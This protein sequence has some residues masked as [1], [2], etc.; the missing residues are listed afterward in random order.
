MHSSNWLAYISL[1]LLSTLSPGPAVLLAMSNAS[2]QGLSAAGLSSLGNLAGLLC[3]S[4]AALLG[5]GTVLPTSSTLFVGLKVIG[6]GYLVY[7]VYLGIR[8]FRASVNVFESI[9][10]AATAHSP[11]RLFVEGATLALTNPKAIFSSQPSF[12]T[13]STEGVQSSLNFLL[14][15]S[16]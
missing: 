10:K 12:H 6:A 2:T 7:L 14:S 16:S 3:L 8:K 5:I 9:E 1:V 13:L 15:Q 4:S 11:M